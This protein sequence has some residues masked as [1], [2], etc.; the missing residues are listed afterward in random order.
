MLAGCDRGGSA[1]AP[2]NP[3]LNPAPGAPV[4]GRDQH[5][6][7]PP[8]EEALVSRILARSPPVD[9]DYLRT[10]LRNPRQTGIRISNKSVQ[11]LLDTL[12]VLRQARLAA[13][14]AERRLSVDQL[15]ATVVLVPRLPAG[16]TAVV[17]RRSRRIPRDLIL[18]PADGASPA[19]VAPAV[20][21]LVKLRRADSGAVTRDRRV[22][23]RGTAL[24]R[25]WKEG[26]LEE[27][28]TRDLARLREAPLTQ[29]D[30]VGR[31]RS[32][33]IWVAR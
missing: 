23:V 11:P 27:Q 20:A 14:E 22:V 31:V 6:A 32:I 33:T 3:A 18:L 1:V 25:S 13:E 5:D 2:E 12:N 16:V 29:V 21:A 30:G 4:Y 10:I 8:Q 28:V 17:E 24:P 7:L 9:A 15:K 26:G 19:S